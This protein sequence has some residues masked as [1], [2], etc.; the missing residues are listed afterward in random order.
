MA[1][2]SGRHCATAGPVY[3]VQKDVS[4]TTNVAEANPQVVASLRTKMDAWAD[5]LGAALAHIPAPAKF[6]AKPAPAGEVLEVTVTVTA[7][8]KAK[9][10]LIVPFG[11]YDGPL[12]AT[13][14]VEYD[15]ATAPESLREGFFYSPFKGNEDKGSSLV[16]KRGEGFDQFGRE[17]VAGPA[18]KGGP[19]VWEHRVIGAI[20]EAPSAFGRQCLVFRGGQ[21]GTYKVYLD[22][23]RM[24]HA[25]GTTTSIWA[26]GED[27]RVR[28]IKDTESFIGVSVRAVPLSAAAQTLPRT[29]N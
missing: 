4:E 1:R 25:D 3:D 18:P 19:G 24:R 20:R 16:F 2:T 12:M 9:D 7:Q 26:S 10:T 6:D 5:S 17:Q 29:E 22:N 28:A 15:V 8:A 21:P 13:D 23:L 11:T 27:T 14:W